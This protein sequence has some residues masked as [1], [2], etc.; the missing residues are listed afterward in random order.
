MPIDPDFNM[1]RQHDKMLIIQVENRL[2]TDIKKV[3]TLDDPRLFNDTY[4]ASDRIFALVECLEV[5]GEEPKTIE[6]SKFKFK[7]EDGTIL[8]KEWLDTTMLR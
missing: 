3:D 1:P 8:D 6:W 5:I 4:T 7:A 2:T